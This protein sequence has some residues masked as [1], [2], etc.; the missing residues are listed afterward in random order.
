MPTRWETFGI[1][2]SGGLVSNLSR[3]QH[4]VKMPGAPRVMQNFEPSENGGYRR[5]NGY[6]KFDEAPV[7]T[8]GGSL[9]QG[10]GQTGTTLVVANL[11]EAPAAGDSFT[12]AGVSGTY[13]I[14]TGGV[15]YSST[16]K[17]AT[18]TLTTSLDS[19]PA[20]K[21]ALTWT[22]NSNKIEGLHFSANLSSTVALRDGVLWISTGSGWTKKSTP[23][24]GTVLVAGGSQTGTTLNVD[25]IADDDYKPKIGDTFTITGVE[26]V[27][28]VTATPTVSS[29]ATGL[30]IY[31][32]LD[33]SPADNAPITF[34]NSTHSGGTKARFEAF[35][36]DGNPRV[37][38]VDGTNT[39]ACIC[40][41]SNYSTIQGSADIVGAVNVVEFKDH[42]FFAK[43]DL[44]TFSAP[45]DRLDY[46]PANGAGSFRL[47]SAV[48]G[49]IPFRTQLICFAED[50]IKNLSGSSEADFVLTDITDK[51]GCPEPD[52][53]QEIGGDILFMGPDG[54]RYLGGTD[55]FGD[56]ALQ[57]ASRAIHREMNDFIETSEDFSSVVIRKKNQYRVFKYRPSQPE[58]AIG[59]V[60]MQKLDQTGQGIEWGTLLGINA[61]RAS[62]TYVDEEEVVI[63]SND[64]GYVY[65]MESG[66]SYDGTAIVARLYTPYMPV[67]DPSIRKT[68]YDIYTYLDPEDD[69]SGTLS[70]RY[71]FNDPKV[72][73]P[74]SIDIG[75]GDLVFLYGSGVYGTA[76]Y[77][78]LPET[79]S[80]VLTTG[81]FFTVS[82]EYEF[83]EDGT[84][85]APFTL[86]TIT[87]SY[88]TEDRK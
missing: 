53:I 4:G 38:M 71:N 25:G 22:N 35:N 68:L 60:G 37:V 67:N 7:P 48:T 28:T 78:G 87:L 34:L 11:H 29:G 59:Y 15:S 32:A 63:F 6:T 10:S 51:L 3:L 50:Q 82:L 40:S 74:A 70:V 49:L 33:S 80:R 45:F 81:S 41:F 24:Y 23:T 88:S 66:N 5:I 83:G 42:L 84:V 62:S 52:T 54:I 13:T 73:Q 18:L 16:N 43:D 2:L 12:I 27:Y 14:D 75:G 39:P 57:L 47:R 8:F 86:D 44:V 61:Y 21:A 76:V 85:M 31:P 72:I 17:E 46:S 19:S 79:F 56:F 69:Y 58:N 55:S 65:R 26:L 20:D 30:T 9:V 64:D 36:F 77:S 1:E